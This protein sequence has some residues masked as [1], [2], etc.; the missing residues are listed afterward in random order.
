[1]SV[2]TTLA[3]RSSCDTHPMPEERPGDRLRSD[4]RQN[5]S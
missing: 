3:F 5:L 4:T 1:M 2:G